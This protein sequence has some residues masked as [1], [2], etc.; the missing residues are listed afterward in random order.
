MPVISFGE[1]SQQI[2]GGAGWAFRQA[3]KDLTPYARG[4]GEFLAAIEQAEQIGY[5]GIEHLAP[6]LRGI[7]VAAIQAMCTG[8][9]SGS[10]PSTISQSLPGD[11]QAHA[12][13]HEAIK[14]LL[15]MA[16]AA[17]PAHR[18]G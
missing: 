17:D 15:A 11:R 8:I 9:I 7:V 14:T 4:T 13:Y 12:R 2:W 5:L 16:N 6:S 1:E 3:L 18:Q 10:R